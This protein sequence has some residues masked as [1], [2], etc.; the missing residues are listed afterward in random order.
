MVEKE[1]WGGGYNQDQFVLARLFLGCYPL[2]VT[3]QGYGH[4]LGVTR[5]QFDFVVSTKF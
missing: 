4:A 5:K 2:L 3:T 1:R